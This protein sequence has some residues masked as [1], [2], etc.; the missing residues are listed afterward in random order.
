MH[1]DAY[2][3][4][5]EARQRQL[6]LKDP[7]ERKKEVETLREFAPR[8]LDGYARAKRHKPSGIAGK[9]TVLR[10]HLLPAL[11]DKRLNVI[12]NE[13]VQAL[14]LRLTERSPKTVNNVLTVLSVLL[15]K[16]VE[17][18]VIDVPPCAVRLLPISKSTTARFYD[19]EEFGR[20]V[21]AAK[22]DGYPAYFIALLGGEAG[23]RCGEMMAL[24]W[25]DV[26]L[27][28]RQLAVA[29]SESKGHVTAT[30]GGRVR[31]VPMTVRL[32]AGTGSVTADSKDREWWRR[33]ESVC[34]I[35]RILEQSEQT[36]ALHRRDSLESRG[37]GTKQ[38]QQTS[39]QRSRK[40]SENE[41]SPEVGGQPAAIV[42]HSFAHGIPCEGCAIRAG[43]CVPS[44]ER[45][46][47]V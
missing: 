13:D 17:W 1:L 36:E 24:E 28:K 35:L 5:A 34:P 44:R 45:I 30:K 29:R 6:M 27:S 10:A 3:R 15:K 40:A 2:G 38:V 41:G 37:P 7:P 39:F 43:L 31:Y 42:W 47:S 26:D 22:D 14:K 20:V 4:A 33:R 21:Q 18:Q 8:F 25:S 23:L 9:A 19:F 16:A 32:A 11:G 12:S 46:R